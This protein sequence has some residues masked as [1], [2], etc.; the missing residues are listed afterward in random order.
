MTLKTKNKGETWRV[1]SACWAG[2]LKW[3]STRDEGP[4]QAVRAMIDLSLIQSIELSW[5]TLSALFR[6][7]SV[8]SGAIQAAQKAF[9]KMKPQQQLA[10]I[11]QGLAARGLYAG[12][13]RRDDRTIAPGHRRTSGRTCRHSDCRRSRSIT[14]CMANPMARPAQPLFPPVPGI[15]SAFASRLM[16]RT[17]CLGDDIPLI[18]NDERASFAVTTVEKA[19]VI[20]FLHQTRKSA[21]PRIFPKSAAPQR[22]VLRC[23]AQDTD[24]ARSGAISTRSLPKISNKPEY[25]TAPLAPSRAS[26]GCRVTCRRTRKRADTLPDAAV[27]ERQ[28]PLSHP[29]AISSS[30]FVQERFAGATRRGL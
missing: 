11:A 13:S 4:M 16:G 26:P 17:S 5:C 30:T 21:R 22:D 14:G 19:H 28:A 6:D 23:R 20:P 9:D 10:R 3:N 7:P 18:P 2:F 1:I 27:I 25:I 29:P 12:P 24:P 15:R 8:G